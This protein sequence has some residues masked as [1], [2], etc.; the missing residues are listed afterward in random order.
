MRGVKAG[1]I[2]SFFAQ[3][4][5][6]RAATDDGRPLVQS[7]YFAWEPRIIG[8][9]VNKSGHQKDSGF[10]G[11]AKH[12]PEQDAEDRNKSLQGVRQ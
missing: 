7:D 11:Q 12:A 8:L 2:I 6:V 9:S 3:K 4:P 5:T 1:D 10:A